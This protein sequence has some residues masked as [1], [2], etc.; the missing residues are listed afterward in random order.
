MRYKKINTAIY[1]PRTIVDNNPYKIFASNK[2][3]KNSN[4][5]KNN[6][7]ALPFDPYITKKNIRFICLQIKN[8]YKKN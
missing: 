7:L 1:Y 3:L 4:F 8:F 5:L 6:I 2:I